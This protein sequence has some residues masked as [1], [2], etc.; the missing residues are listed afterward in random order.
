MRSLGGS[1]LALR[2]THHHEPSA[3]AASLMDALVTYRPLP[4][5]EAPH[6]L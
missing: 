3:T 1:G 6:G 4:A 5:G 2:F